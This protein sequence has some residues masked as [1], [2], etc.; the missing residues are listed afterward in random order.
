MSEFLHYIIIGIVQGV[1]EFLPISSSGH[2]VIFGDLLDMGAEDMTLEIL[3]H[4]GTLIAVF[5]AYRQ[6]VL[7]LLKAIPSVPQ[8]ISSTKRQELSDE[9]QDNCRLGLFIIASMF[10]AAVIGLSFKDQ[11]EQ[12]R[13]LYLVGFSL[14]FTAVILFSIKFSKEKSDKLN[15]QKVIFIGFAQAVSVLPGVSRSGTTI[16]M[17]LWLGLKRE[18]AARFSFLMSIPV[19]LGASIIKIGE[20]FGRSYSST[21]LIQ[22]AVAMISAAVVGYLCIVLI[23][24]LVTQNRFHYFGFYCISIAL[25]CLLY[26]APQSAKKKAATQQ[27][28]IELKHP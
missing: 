14:L 5:F 6:D 22:Y 27:Q 20:M 13:S 4:L 25:V 15:L 26:F 17:A 23:K 9:T 2:L 19:I 21:Q 28:T 1:A 18:E 24:K 3:V 8:F 12:A 7:S 16:C 10:P 11:L